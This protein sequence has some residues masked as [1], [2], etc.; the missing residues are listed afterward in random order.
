ML[1]NADDALDLSEFR[2][3][4]FFDGSPIRPQTSV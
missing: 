1:T 3:Q 2:L 4:R